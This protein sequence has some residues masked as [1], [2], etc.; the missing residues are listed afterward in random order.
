[1]GKV[2][3]RKVR[4]GKVRIRKVRIRKVR[5]RK[6]RM[7]KVRMGEVRQGTDFWLHVL[8]CGWDGLGETVSRTRDASRNHELRRM[9]EV[10][11][12]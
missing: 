12:C 1:M 6:V 9:Q 3:I 5:I 10:V 11:R 2:R 8:E 4:M 7:G